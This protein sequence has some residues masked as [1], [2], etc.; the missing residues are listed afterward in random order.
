[1]Y[2][3]THRRV[4]SLEAPS[5]SGYSADPATNTLVYGGPSTS[6]AHS[7]GVEENASY[8]AGGVG[9]DLGSGGAAPDGG[10]VAKGYA[11]YANQNYAASILPHQHQQQQQ[12]SSSSVASPYPTAQPPSQPMGGGMVTTGEPYY[13]YTDPNN[14]AQYQQYYQYAQYQN[15]YAA[16]QQHQKQQMQMQPG[17]HSVWNSSQPSYH[18]GSNVGGG[19]GGSGPVQSAHAVGNAGYRAPTYAPSYPSPSPYHNPNDNASEVGVGPSVVRVHTG[20]RP[21][22]SKASVGAGGA[23]VSGYAGAG[24]SVQQ[25]PLGSMPRQPGTSGSAAVAYQGSVAT[26]SSSAMS[27]QQDY[28]QYYAQYYGN[29]MPPVA[30]QHLQ[31]HGH[32]GGVDLQPGEEGGVPSGQYASYYYQN[33]SSNAPPMGRVHAS[34]APQSRPTQHQGTHDMQYSGYSDPNRMN[35]AASHA[36]RQPYNYGYYNGSAYPTPAQ[37]AQ[38]SYYPHPQQPHQH[39]R[40]NQSY[41]YAPQQPITR[42]REEVE[43]EDSVTTASGEG[44]AVKAHEEGPWEES[45]AATSAGEGSQGS[46]LRHRG[47]EKST[48]ALLHLDPNAMSEE[49]DAGGKGVGPSSDIVEDDAAAGVVD[50]LNGEPSLNVIASLQLPTSTG[51]E[52]GV[53]SP[54]SSVQEAEGSTR[55]SVDVDKPQGQTTNTSPPCSA[56]I[57]R[58]DRPS[59]APTT[60]FLRRSPMLHCST[61][62]FHIYFCG[63]VAGQ[64]AASQQQ[65]QHLTSPVDLVSP[66]AAVPAVCAPMQHLVS[67]EMSRMRERGR[68]GSRPPR[69][70]DAEEEAVGD[71]EEEGATPGE[72]AAQLPPSNSERWNYSQEATDAGEGDERM[73]VQGQGEGSYALEAQSFGN[74]SEIVSQHGSVDVSAATTASPTSPRSLPGRPHHSHLLAYHRHNSIYHGSFS[75]VS[76]HSQHQ[77]HHHYH[78]A[79]QS[80]SYTGQQQGTPSPRNNAAF[81]LPPRSPAMQPQ[82]SGGVTLAWPHG[83]GGKVVA[84][85][86]HPTQGSAAPSPPIA[87]ESGPGAAATMGLGY[88][89]PLPPS[90]VVTVGGPPSVG[91]NRRGHGQAS[92]NT[93][94][95]AHKGPGGSGPR[96]QP[97]HGHTHSSHRYNS[98]HDASAAYSGMQPGRPA[99]IYEHHTG[100]EVWLEEFHSGISFNPAVF[101]NLTCL[102]NAISPYV[103]VSYDFAFPCNED[104]C[105]LILPTEACGVSQPSPPARCVDDDGSGAVPCMEEAEV[106]SDR[107]VAA[108]PPRPAEAD[109]TRYWDFT[110]PQYSEPVVSLRAIWECL[111]SPFGC[112]VDLA[113][114]IFPAPM[115]P[116]TDRLVYTPLLSG[117]RIRFHRASPAY[118]RLAAVRRA[119]RGGASASPE[120]TTSNGEVGRAPE[121]STGGGT[122]VISAEETPRIESDDRLYD[123]DGVL[124]WSATD[125]PNN[126]SVLVEQIV[127][128]ARSDES[129]SVLLTATTA[130]IDHQSW[131]ALMWQPVF[132]GGHAAKHSCGSFL[133]FYLLRSPRHLFVPFADKS[134]GAALNSSWQSPVF[135]GDRAALSFDLWNLPRNYHIG[136]LSSLPSSAMDGNPGSGAEDG[137]SSSSTSRER[138]FSDDG[139]LGYAESIDDSRDAGVLSPTQVMAETTA[140]PVITTAATAAPSMYVRIPLVGL[141]P[142]R[143]RSDVWFKPVYDRGH[144]S[145]GNGGGGGGAG[146]NS[147]VTSSASNAHLFFAPL[148]LMVTALQL[149]SWNAYEEWTRVNPA[150][151]AGETAATSPS[152][153][154]TGAAEEA[155]AVAPTSSSSASPVQLVN[156]LTQIVEEALNSE[157][158]RTDGG[159]SASPT[160]DAVPALGGGG[161]SSHHASSPDGASPVASIGGVY[162][163]KGV[164]LLTEAARS[165]RTLR[166]ASHLDTI[167][168]EGGGGAVVTPMTSPGHSQTPT[169]EADRSAAGARHCIASE[170]KE[171]SAPSPAS[172]G[173]SGGMLIAGGTR[174]SLCGPSA[175]VIVGLLDFYQWAQYDTPLMALANTYCRR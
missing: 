12:P 111:D 38:Q 60:K 49:A 146:S 6:A 124:T 92:H 167:A 77:Y 106:R 141:I 32:A 96:M 81:A 59:S 162:F 140:F 153:G 173:V 34:Y 64:A 160:T 72:S 66:S 126:R 57:S 62:P 131:V 91:G 73:D 164:S 157:R 100:S 87:I 134:E 137:N 105:Q 159:G 46:P 93:Y 123:D 172:G 94:P 3:S 104:Q 149:M 29:T 27:P 171:S 156:P 18:T 14:A 75:S 1:M 44:D 68:H 85:P 31:Q 69:G 84:T 110:G 4:I 109:P 136:R 13:D 78:N 54:L 169:K 20:K 2:P 127:E 41:Y 116:A 150:A 97:G 63:A 174:S 58:T 143:C 114:P 117:F 40:R 158:N 112:V 163:S 139:G 71:N 145:S 170:E 17:A 23:T 10:G 9:Y 55:H 154:D 132:C 138:F 28:Y 148:F 107:H 129:Y 53:K 118:R 82:S 115:R 43:G 119:K 101:G 90:S 11:N 142:N 76:S 30:S 42:G 95:N 128:L 168:E 108:M 144:P 130:D 65:Q 48:T 8:A 122:S 67:K 83:D 16:Q 25:P 21:V 98:P 56:S 166:D 33:P 152:A 88:Y 79:P 39:P 155:G 121:D 135:R 113:E 80:I 165:Y 102:V 61:T 26:P 22:A 47:A 147:K 151:P 5:Q 133:A 50:D 15:Y 125:R 74:V 35:S 36:S 7:V 99:Y 51:S 70:V 19:G 161:G 45:T 175:R 52:T 89:P 103:P 37:G 86:P 120:E 24:H